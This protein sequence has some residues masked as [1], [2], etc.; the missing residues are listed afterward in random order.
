MALGAIGV[1]MLVPVLGFP[2]AFLLTAASMIPAL[3]L[4]RT[5]APAF[6]LRL[7]EAR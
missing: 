5:P 4:A 2:G 1:G 6:G 3:F 7:A